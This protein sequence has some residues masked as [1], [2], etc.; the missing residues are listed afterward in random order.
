MLQV[1]TVGGVYMVVGGAPD[2]IQDH[3]T[4]VAALALHMAKSVL[5]EVPDYTIRIGKN[6]QHPTRACLIYQ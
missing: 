2:R 3:C 4:Q 1:E 5:E 6:T